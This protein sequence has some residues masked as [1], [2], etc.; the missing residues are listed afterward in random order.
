MPFE[1]GRE[2]T[3]GRPK[4]GQNKTTQK[5]KDFTQK[6]MDSATEDFD[7]IFKGSK[8]SDILRF[9]ASVAPKSLDIKMEIPLNP[10]AEALQKIQADDKTDISNSNNDE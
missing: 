7:R 10:I 8:P 1:Q 4:G 3:G 9:I 2:K 5:I 6:F